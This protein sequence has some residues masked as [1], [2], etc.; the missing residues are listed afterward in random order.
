MEILST[1]RSIEKYT[2]SI[3]CYPEGQELFLIRKASEERFFA[4]LFTDE[5]L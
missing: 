2:E 5:D 4:V 3:P 1:L